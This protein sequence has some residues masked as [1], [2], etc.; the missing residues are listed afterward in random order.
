MMIIPNKLNMRTNSH[1]YSQWNF[2]KEKVNFKY[3]YNNK[4]SSFSQ[5]KKKKQILDKTS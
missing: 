5:K 3:N 2:Q 1:T 4:L